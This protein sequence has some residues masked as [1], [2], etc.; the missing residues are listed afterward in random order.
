VVEFLVNLDN[1]L[2]FF[3]NQ[4]GHYPW[5]DFLAKF[6]VDWPIFLIILLFIY[7][8]RH[9]KTSWLL[10]ATMFFSAVVN[11]LILKNIFKRPRPYWIF[12]EAVHVVGSSLFWSESWRPPLASWAFPSGHTA[13]AA[14][15]AYVVFLR[16][17]RLRGLVV[18]LTLLSCLARVFA[19]VHRPLDVLTGVFVGILVGILSLRLFQL[20]QIKKLVGIVFK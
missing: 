9:R 17:R 10:L 8:E 4:R 7:S 6:L 2:F 12:D 15:V 5:T 3:I 1:Q 14:A 16:H 18:I 13:L 19:G 11:S 20:K